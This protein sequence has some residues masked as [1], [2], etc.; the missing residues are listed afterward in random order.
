[1]SNEHPTIYIAL[2]PWDLADGE[3]YLDSS[4][5]YPYLKTINETRLTTEQSD[6]MLAYLK[7]HNTF[8]FP[9]VASAETGLR[10]MDIVE[11]ST[12]FTMGTAPLPSGHPLKGYCASP[13]PFSWRF[14]IRPL[15]VLCIG[16]GLLVNILLFCLLNFWGED[17]SRLY[18][19]LAVLVGGGSS[20]MA[21]KLYVRYMMRQCNRY[22]RSHVTSPYVQLLD[23]ARSDFGVSIW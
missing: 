7:K 8:L 6:K 21:D 1:M 23:K 9:Y 17:I 20:W 14:W 13:S 4:F 10:L 5:L 22:L 18:Y 16:T 12:H 11:R 19:M 15:P 3:K 2:L